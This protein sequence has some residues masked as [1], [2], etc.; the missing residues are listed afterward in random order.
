MRIVAGSLKGRVSRRPLGRAAADVR[1][2][3]RDPVQRARAAIEGARVLD[4]FAG[5]GAVGIEALS[6]GAAHVTFVERDPRAIALIEA[7]LRALRRPRP[8]CYYPRWVCRHG[9]AAG[10]ADR[11]TS[12]FSIRRTAR[13]TCW[14]RSTPRNRSSRTRRCSSSNTPAGTRRLNRKA[15]LTRTRLLTSGDSALA[16]YRAADARNVNETAA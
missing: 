14:Q 8:L 7:N 2:A 9:P 12:S 1:S 3:A 13:A 6:R 11:S 15:P 5:T 4:G 16:F 10:N